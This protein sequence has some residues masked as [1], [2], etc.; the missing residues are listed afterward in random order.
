VARCRECQPFSVCE[1]KRRTPRVPCIDIFFL[2]NTCLAPILPVAFQEHTSA[3]S[4]K[5]KSKV[6][7]VG[8]VD[9][10]CSAMSHDD[11]DA[12]LRAVFGVFGTISA[13]ALSQLKEDRSVSPGQ[14]RFAHVEFTKQSS[15]VAALDASDDE[16]TRISEGLAKIYGIASAC[17]GKSSAELKARYTLSGVQDV[18]ELRE[19]INMALQDFEDEEEA[20]RREMIRRTKEPDADGFITAGPTKKNKRMDHPPGA[21]HG[22]KRGKGIRARAAKKKSPKELTN[23]YRFQMK[24]QKRGELNSLRQKFEE[25]RARIASIKAQRGFNPLG[26]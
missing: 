26:R 3:S 17:R 21:K 6:L 19:D 2:S 24:E 9:Y 15:V 12:Y 1:G 25:D 20:R 14:A 13:I 4:E 18:D 23:F 5:G 8:N 16:Y 10:G 11:V 22:N 7:F